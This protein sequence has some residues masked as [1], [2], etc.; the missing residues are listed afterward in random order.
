LTL[1]NALSIAAAAYAISLARGGIPQIQHGEIKLSLVILFLVPPADES[2]K[3]WSS[4]TS[5]ILNLFVLTVLL[6]THRPTQWPFD[7]Y[8][9]QLHY[10]R[11]PDPKWREK[12]GNRTA[13]RRE[14]VFLRRPT[15]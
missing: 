15:P 9:P 11:G 1:T 3:P 13:V 7:R 10:M 2:Q 8:R 12:N 5:A 4:A 14:D 6:A